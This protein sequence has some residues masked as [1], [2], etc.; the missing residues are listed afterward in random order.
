M[1][2][3]AA[4]DYC[5]SWCFMVLVTTI[6]VTMMITSLTT[7]GCSFARALGFYGC[8]GKPFSAEGLSRL[9]T[10]IQSGSKK[11]ISITSS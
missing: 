11:W 5:C 1:V 7:M 10:A 3:I 2:S 8:L 6:A 9:L 4:C